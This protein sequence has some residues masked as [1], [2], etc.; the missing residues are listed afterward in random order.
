[1]PWAQMPVFG[2]PRAHSSLPED[3][4]LITGIPVSEENENV[5]A[6]S[7]KPEDNEQPEE[8]NTDEGP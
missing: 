4:V 2:S 6:E 1:M 3:D 5:T 8:A 7:A